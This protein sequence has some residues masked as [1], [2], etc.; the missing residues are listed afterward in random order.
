M[1][2]PPD[3]TAVFSAANLFVAGG[4]TEPKYSSKISGYSF[5]PVSVS[6]KM[7]PWRS[8]S[9][10][11]LWYRRLRTRTGPPHRD[12]TCLLGLGDAEA[13]VGVLDV[14]G[15]FFPAVGLALG[16][17]HVVLDRVEIDLA[18]IGTPGG[19]RLTLEQLEC[20]QPALQHP[21]GLVLQG[22]DAAD[23]GI[24]QPALGC[25]AGRIGIMPAEA[26]LRQGLDLF[27]LGRLLGCRGA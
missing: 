2:E 14:G 6:R 13:V 16:G 22:R 4:I 21:F 5:R 23:H 12:H 8:S 9:S 26:V 1:N 20:L 15:Q 11:I 10:L 3:Q 19:H 17:A 24:V 7:T 27:G 18:E 25:R